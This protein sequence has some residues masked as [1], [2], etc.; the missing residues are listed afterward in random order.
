MT[1][2]VVQEPDASKNILSANDFG[3]LEFILPARENM[4]YSSAPTVSRI[5]HALR[6]F[7]DEDY[8]LLIGDPAA[9]GVAVHFALKNNRQKA[10]LLK[11]DK[12]EYRYYSIEVEA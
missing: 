11:W 12:R 2:F 7:T 10:K 6:N 9:I 8:L 3:E 5:K 4:M 1:V